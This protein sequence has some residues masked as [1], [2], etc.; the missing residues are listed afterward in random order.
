MS[1]TNKLANQVKANLLKI[2]ERERNRGRGF[3]NIMKEAWN[4]IYENSTMSAQTLR[5]DA[6]KFRKTN[7]YSVL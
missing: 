3:M 1:N 2:E 4:D 7:L 5:D 6:A